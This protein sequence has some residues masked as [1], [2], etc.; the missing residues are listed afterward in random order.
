MKARGG[1]LTARLGRL[2]GRTAA[3]SAPA[4]PEPRDEN[5]GWPP[6]RNSPATKSWKPPPTSRGLS[7]SSATP[8]P[9]RGRLPIR[10]HTRFVMGPAGDSTEAFTYHFLPFGS[11]RHGGS[12][13]HSRQTNTKLAGTHYDNHCRSIDLE[14]FEPGE[15]GH[16]LNSRTAQLQP[17]EVVQP[18]QGGHVRHLGGVEPQLFEGV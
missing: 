18:V 5:G 11:T 1:S 14:M 9:M 2:E 13:A 7:R 17:F 15:R 12:P 10:G 16:V 3:V 6:S 8:R 4:E